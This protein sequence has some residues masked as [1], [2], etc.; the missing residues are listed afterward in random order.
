[1][2]NKDGGWSS[3]GSWDSCS[4]TC[5]VGQKLQHR[6]CTNPS[7]SVYGKVCEGNTEAFAVCINRPCE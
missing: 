3:W 1:M 4:V 6:T 7:P 5:G 2:C